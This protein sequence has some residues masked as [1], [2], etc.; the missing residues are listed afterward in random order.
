MKKLKHDAMLDIGRDAV[1]QAYNRHL[2]T[3]DE[4]MKVLQ[5]FEKV[6]RTSE[7]M[8]M[9]GSLEEEEDDV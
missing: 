5:A 3:S 2:H 9:N 1:L 8:V 6:V 4:F 7:R